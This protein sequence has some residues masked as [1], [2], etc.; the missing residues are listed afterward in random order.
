[1]EY[2]ICQRKKHKIVQYSEQK[3]EKN[4]VK[5]LQLYQISL[6]S[7]PKQD[8]SG[9]NEIESIICMD[10]SCTI[11]KIRVMDYWTRCEYFCGRIKI[12]R[13]TKMKIT[14]RKEQNFG[15]NQSGIRGVDEQKIIW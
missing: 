1:M 5:I 14:P 9:Q 4:S 11:N 6:E 13:S 3:K 12:S 8:I 10:M 15:Q 7:V 2:F